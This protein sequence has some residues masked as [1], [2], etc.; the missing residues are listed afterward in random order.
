MLARHLPDFFSKLA[1]FYTPWFS[2]ISTTCGRFIN[3]PMTISSRDT[4][5]DHF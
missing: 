3:R 4:R 2:K 1:T 5:V